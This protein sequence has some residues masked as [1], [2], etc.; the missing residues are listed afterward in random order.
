[1]MK[2]NEFVDTLKTIEKQPTV[3]YSVAG[4][5]WC[6]WNGS[7]WNM[8]CV[9]MVKGVLW[10]FDFNKSASHGGAVYLSNGVADDNADGIMQ[11]CYDVSRD[12]RNIQV[13]ELMHMDG[14]VGVYIG[15]RKVVEATAWYGKVIISTVEEDGRRTKDGNSGGYWKE[16][17]KLE[18]VDYSQAPTPT[19]TPV[20]YKIGDR[21]SIN[22]VYISSDSDKMLTPAITEGTITRIIDGARNPYLLDDG[23]IGWVNNDCI[24]GI[25]SDNKRYYT[26][27]PGDTLWD[28]AKRFYGDGSKYP[29]IAKANNIENPDLIYPGQKLYIPE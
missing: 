22:G 21:V 24:I 25:I 27:V 28:I 3:Y 14:H 10:G 17:G 18:Y 23:N 8:D 2:V 26:I 15:D 16:H 6:A 19:P 4:G 11:R 20:E 7:S 13:G 9:C 1:M 12:F 5:A 29:I